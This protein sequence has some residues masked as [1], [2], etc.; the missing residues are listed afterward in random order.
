M[1]FQNLND[2]K[3]DIEKVIKRAITLEE[4]INI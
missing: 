3:I 1:F 2:K 4:A